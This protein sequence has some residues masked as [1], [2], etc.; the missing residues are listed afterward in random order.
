M[1][2]GFTLIEL[3]VV[4]AIIAIL[5]AILFPV[6]AKAREKA[7]QSSCLSNAKQLATGLLSYVQDYDEMLPKC[8]MG[9]GSYFA[10]LLYP[11][12]KNSQ[13]FLCPSMKTNW[14]GLA[15]SLSFGVPFSALGYGWNTG[16]F[17]TR[18]IGESPTDGWPFY[19][20]AAITVPAETIAMG[21]MG[22]AGTVGT[23][24]LPNIFW[25][26]WSVYAGKNFASQHNGGGNYAFLDGHCKWYGVQSIYGQRR[27]FT[28]AE[29]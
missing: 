15:G 25:G 10:D 29:D 19:S 13:V 24:G 7:R 2:R 20:L 17:A 9:N 18:G 14:C 12:V 26:D 21:D 23:T 6:F 3:L 8:S 28:V 22:P 1:R 4:I 16:D 11:Y 5:A 27:F